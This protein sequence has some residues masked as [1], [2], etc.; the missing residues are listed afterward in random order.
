MMTGQS[1]IST[2]QKRKPEFGGAGLSF[3]ETVVPECKPTPLHHTSLL[4][5]CC[6]KKPWFK[7]LFPPRNTL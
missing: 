4:I 5:V 3:M 7:P 2:R 6:R 1:A